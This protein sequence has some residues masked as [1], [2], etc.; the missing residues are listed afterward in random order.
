MR[1]G[2]MPEN[3]RPPLE[4]QPPLPRQP[5]NR[6]N[7]SKS[8][9]GEMPLSRLHQQERA[10]MQS[11]TRRNLIRGAAALPAAALIPT[12]ALANADA[13][14]CKLAREAF[15]A[16]EA[17][18]AVCDEV[19]A[20]E[21]I[22]SA[23]EKRNPRPAMRDCT[24]RSLPVEFKTGG[25]FQYGSPRYEARR[26]EADSDITAAVKEWELAVTRWG[27]RKRLVKT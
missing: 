2:R 27:E 1:S 7:S 4:H 18:E 21:K 23:W 14:L 25:E 19:N 16:W 6:I 20:S 9:F 13:A 10:I 17:L 22:V 24:A 11:L 3:T 12:V 8:E 15:A 5:M 26:Q